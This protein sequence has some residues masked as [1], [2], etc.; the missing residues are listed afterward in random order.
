M[1]VCMVS[2][3]LITLLTNAS[4]QHNATGAGS[5]EGLNPTQVHESPSAQEQDQ[6]QLAGK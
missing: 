2:I 3:Q 5:R 1:C 6:L 4:R